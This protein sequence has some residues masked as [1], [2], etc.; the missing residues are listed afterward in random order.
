MSFLARGEPPLTLKL[1]NPVA[2]TLDVISKNF[3]QLFSCGN[4]RDVRLDDE[5]ADFCT[6]CF[7]ATSLNLFYIK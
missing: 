6:C 7:H 1:A 4:A 5:S 2:D 3:S